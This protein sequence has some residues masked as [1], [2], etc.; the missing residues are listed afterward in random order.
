MLSTSMVAAAKFLDTISKVLGVT[1]E[2]SDAVSTY[3]HV[4]L[5]DAPSKTMLPESECPETWMRT[6]PRQRP[7]SC[8]SIEDPVPS[9]ERNLYSHPLASLLWE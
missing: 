7:T 9:R 2:A 8:D 4:R 5:V 3:T 6:S 1:G